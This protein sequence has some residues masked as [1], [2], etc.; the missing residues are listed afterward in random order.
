MGIRAATCLA[1][2]LVLAPAA[3][4]QTPPADCSIP[5]QN[6]FVRDTMAEH[7][8]WYREMPAIDPA[9]YPSPDAV[10]EALRYRP[11]DTTFSYVGY[12]AAEEAF[13]SESRFIGFGFG[14][15][16]LGPDEL[17]VAQV[18][19]DSPASAAGLDRGSLL[20]EIGGV[21][22]PDLLA[23]GAL[24]A[25]LGPAQEGVA[26]TVRFQTRDGA[27]REERMVK[28]QVTI[29]TVSLSRVYS[30]GG[31]KVAYVV[32]RN[33]VQPSVAALDAAF[34][35][36]FHELVHDV[37]LDLRYNGGGLVSVAQHLAGLLGGHRTSGLTFARF[38][39]N[40]RNSGRNQTLTFPNPEWALGLRRLIVI[41]TRAS[42]SASELVINALRPFV[43]VVLVGET[44]YGKPVGQ[45]GY[46]F[47]DRV[48]YPVAF[49][50]RNAN[51]EGDFFS[52]LGPDCPAADDLF[53]PFGD[54]AEA[55]LAQALHYATT[56]G[57]APEGV[58]A[59]RAQ[60]LRQPA[61]DRQPHRRSPWQV[62][63]GAY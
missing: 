33:F 55:S 63:L 22:V 23:A 42:A 16:L 48:L 34:E 10:L 53:H 13:Y 12:R 45:Y 51:D 1:A 2:V 54:P 20:L 44:T 29:P 35:P 30:V 37:V 39:H 27:V 38:V 43:D 17:R 36:L 15:K 11:F 9:A 56:G 19:P 50:L 52:G 4:A 5:A 3:S 26:A 47:C 14:M 59:A 24:D 32:F 58:A 7:Y 57:C 49:T 31:R 61:G 28:R 25:A 8:L 62:L 41:T 18:F 40:D 6:A 21:P 60:S 46:N